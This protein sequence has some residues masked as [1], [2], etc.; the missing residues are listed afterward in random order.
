M[1]EVDGQ[2]LTLCCSTVAIA[3]VPWFSP[4]EAEGVSGGF[5]FPTSRYSLMG[6]FGPD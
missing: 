4:D 2:L 5:P 6:R 1:I 3:V